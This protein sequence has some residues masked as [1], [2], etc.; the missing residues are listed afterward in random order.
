[1]DAS[2]HA[3]IVLGQRT[4]GDRS[5]R[6]VGRAQFWTQRQHFVHRRQGALGVLA[7]D[8]VPQVMAQFQLKQVVADNQS[9]QRTAATA[10]WLTRNP[11]GG[12][13]P[14]AELDVTAEHPINHRR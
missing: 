2:K 13:R 12:K 11:L 8:D 14:P 7:D 9:L 1:V 10:R 4:V 5:V 3:A 6:S